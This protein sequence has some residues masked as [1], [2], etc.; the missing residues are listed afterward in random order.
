M[1]SLQSWCTG[2]TR[3]LVRP[4]SQVATIYTHPAFAGVGNLLPQE[5]RVRDGLGGACIFLHPRALLRLLRRRRRDVAGKERVDSVLVD[6]VPR[7][8]R[9][10]V[11]RD[12]QR[13]FLQGTKHGQQHGGRS[14]GGQSLPVHVRMRLVWLMRRPGCVSAV[15]PYDSCSA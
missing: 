8:E 5:V 14:T 4:I 12:M 3:G 13:G 6:H 9:P 10:G 2:A 7:V 11:K 1:P 15:G